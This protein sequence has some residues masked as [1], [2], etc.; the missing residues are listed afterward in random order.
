MKEY[1]THTF[2]C[3][4]ATGDAPDYAR[5]ANDNSYETLGI[6][7]HTPLPGI[8]V[9]QEIRMDISELG[10]YVQAIETAQKRFPGLN[11]LKG[12]ECEYFKEHQ[13]FYT[14]ELR[15]RHGLHY[16]ILAQH[17]FRSNGEWVFFWKGL[18][19]IRELK[20]YTDSLIEGIGSG[21]FDFI[22]HP[23]IFGA[24]YAP[25]DTETIACSRAILSAAKDAGIPVEINTHG[26]RKKKIDTPCGQRYLYPLEPFWELVSAYD[27]P[28][29]VSS[30]AHKPE[31]LGAKIDEAAKLIRRYNLRP[32]DL[33]AL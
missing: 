6:S 28:V 30:D 17:I 5:F 12:M 20:A 24:F 16:L 22:A 18:K 7:D 2:R 15:G 21:L 1:H 33:P 19:G 29:I 3:K 25:W 8:P 9:S 31:D 27:L 14:D 11:I 13:S 32:V 4:H 10:A 23:D 26:Y